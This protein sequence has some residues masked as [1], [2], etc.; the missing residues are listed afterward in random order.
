[1]LKQLAR[2]GAFLL[3]ALG[4]TAIPLEA[5]SACT[6]FVLHAQDGG[7]VYGRTM[8]FGLP[9]H[10]DLVVI[11]RHFALTAT[12]PDGTPGTGLKW[13]TK[14]GVVGMDAL[15]H[16]Q[17]V[18]DGMNEAGLAGGLLYFPGYAGYDKVTPS[19]AHESIASFDL[20]AYVLS[21][22]ATVADVRAALPKL[23]VSNAPNAAFDGPPPVHMTLHDASGAS[24]VV[25]YVRGHLTMFDNSIGVLT[26]AP[27]FQWH[28]ANLGLYLNTSVYDPKPL[29]VGAITISPPSTGDGAPGLPGNMSSPARFVRAFLY[30][31]SAPHLATSAET[32]NQA[33]HILDNFDIAPG[34]IRT[35]ADAKAGGG[36][37]GI[38]TTEWMTV[39]DLKDRS[40]YFRTYDNPQERVFDLTHANFGGNAITVITTEQP[41]RP[42]NV[43]N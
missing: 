3:A 30:S 13:T 31:H 16:T 10:S 43:T 42:I 5:A 40:Y 1:M 34:V 23:L 33:F 41:N 26:N 15:G 37:N 6:S 32:V 2:R 22:F 29:T 11:P 21:N 36:V 39:A 25:E 4:A 19:E 27:N 24:L 17:W 14:Y 20:L 8:E 28:I 38:E 18:V 12:G 9:L 35:S 7:T